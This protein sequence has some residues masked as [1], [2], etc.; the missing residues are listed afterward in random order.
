MRESNSHSIILLLFSCSRKQP[1]GPG[2]PKIGVP[3]YALCCDR[4]GRETI[5]TV[6][7]GATA[8]G[9]QANHS[10]ESEGDISSTVRGAMGELRGG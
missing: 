6:G 10:A 2:V 1:A 9:D 8:G 5:S 4:T 7:G 3:M